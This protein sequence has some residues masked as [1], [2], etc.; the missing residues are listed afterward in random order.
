MAA[1]LEAAGTGAGSFNVH[2][3]HA[4]EG[5]ALRPEGVLAALRSCGV[6]L[7]VAAARFLVPAPTASAESASAVP[8]R[9][10]SLT[11]TALQWRLP[12]RT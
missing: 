7:E 5:F 11:T 3:G 12:A 10:R 9:A 1:I 6:T 4:F 2:P 8:A